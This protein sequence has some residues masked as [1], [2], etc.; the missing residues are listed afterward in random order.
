MSR[1]F[2]GQGM[3]LKSVLLALSV[4]CVIPDLQAE[5]LRIG[6]VTP[7]GHI[8]NR[9]TERFDEN[10]VKA[11]DGKLHIRMS[12]L[13]KLANEQEMI[14]QLQD[15]HM[16]LAIL[17]AGSLATLEPSFSG[18]Y[19]PF[20]FRDVGAA[21]QAT[22]SQASQ[23]MLQSLSGHRIMGMGYAFAGMRQVVATTPVNSIDDFRNLKIRAFPDPVFNDWWTV[24]GASP[25]VLPVS[26]MGPALGN[27]RLDAVDVDLDLLV[28]LKMYQKAPYLTLTNH[29]A[30]PGV[31]VMSLDWWN[32]QTPDNQQMVITA[33]R[34][35]EAW[36]FKQQAAA[37]VSNLELLKRAGA[38]VST[39]NPAGFT[40]QTR[41]VVEKYTDSNETIKRFYQQ[42]QQ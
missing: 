25:V 23:E 2:R 5:S 40:V 28:G 13:A 11:S 38:E 22:S 1:V 33:F 18:W 7:P 35:A 8:W 10:L 14:A 4:L 27:K 17:T 41:E 20:L 37:E 6:M 3:C 19:L 16:Q 39:L 9:V 31:M 42:N 15:G 34:E 29:M 21:A 32:K 24:L 30:F 12:S 26:D 36:G